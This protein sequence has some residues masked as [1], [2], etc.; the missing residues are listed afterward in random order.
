MMT[1]IFITNTHLNIY[2]L[3][4]TGGLK[5]FVTDKYGVTKVQLII[6]IYQCQERWKKNIFYWRLSLWHWY[7]FWYRWFMD[8]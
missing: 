7:M 5:K 1:L 8:M 6:L 3:C 4:I 2:G